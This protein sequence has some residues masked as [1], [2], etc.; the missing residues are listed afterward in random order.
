MYFSHT[1]RPAI[2]E[3]QLVTLSSVSMV[4]M[5]LQLIHAY[6]TTSASSYCLFSYVV[7]GIKLRAF[8][9]LGKCSTSEPHLQPQ[10][11]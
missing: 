9:V 7:L 8:Y 3:V 5:E 11:F 4:S 2:N 6:L 1:V 10:D